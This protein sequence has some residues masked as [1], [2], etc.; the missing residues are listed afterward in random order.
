MREETRC[1]DIGYFLRLPTKVFVYAPSHRQDNTYHNR[2]YTRRGALAGTMP[3]HSSRCTVTFLRSKCNEGCD[4]CIY[5]TVV[6]C[7]D[8]MIYIPY[9]FSSFYCIMSSSVVK[10]FAH[11]AMGRRIDPSWWTHDWC[12]KFRGMCYPVSGM[13]YIKEP[14]RRQRVSSLSRYLN[15]PLPYV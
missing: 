10:G 1:R 13:M 15:G 4:S 11:D 3:D 12:N 2:F 9:V 7:A 14:L 5:V 8:T 6:T